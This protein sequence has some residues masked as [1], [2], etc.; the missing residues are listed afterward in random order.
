M[1]ITKDDRCLLE[2]MSDYADVDDK[3]CNN[4]YSVNVRTNINIK[5]I[6]GMPITRKLIA[7]LKGERN[8][9]QWH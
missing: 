3:Y 5:N 9:Y 6:N 1:I 8:E 4:R 7:L 2:I